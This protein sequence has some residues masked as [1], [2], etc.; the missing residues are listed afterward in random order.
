MRERL[1]VK[2]GE[3]GK[4]RQTSR[5][6]AR[7]L[8]ATERKRQQDRERGKGSREASAGSKRGMRRIPITS[9]SFPENKNI[10]LCA[11]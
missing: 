9:C 7:D 4:R 6:R 3:R 2:K 10:T 1:A 8:E 11:E 5:E